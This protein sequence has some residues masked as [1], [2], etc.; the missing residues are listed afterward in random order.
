MK[1]KLTEL[2]KQA[3]QVA[4]DVVQNVIDLTKDNP[5]TIFTDEEAEEDEFR[6]EECYELPW[7]YYVTKHF[8]YLEGIV[9]EVHGAKI[10]LFMKG[11]D[12]GEIYE[13]EIHQLPQGVL[14]DI[15]ELLIERDENN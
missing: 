13:T 4:I 2:V 14:V 9:Q 8:Y 5:L 6:D 3:N 15:L 12:W 11:D 7:G 1:K 10:K